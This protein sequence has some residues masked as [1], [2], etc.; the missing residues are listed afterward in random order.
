[1]ERGLKVKEYELSRDFS[2][3]GN[4]GYCVQEHIDLGARYDQGISIFG[5]DFYVVTGRPGARKARRKQKSARIG[6]GDRM[7][8]HVTQSWLKHWRFDDIIMVSSIFVLI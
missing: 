3:T 6:F 1:L 4:F 7:K 2:E 8:K 5:M